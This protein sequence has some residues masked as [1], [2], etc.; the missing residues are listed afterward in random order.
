MADYGSRPP[1][2]QGRRPMQT[3]LPCSLRGP[4]SRQRAW[5]P[6]L[7]KSMDSHPLKR[8]DREEIPSMFDT[9]VR[10]ELVRR[11]RAEIAAGTYET[12]EKLDLALGRLLDQLD[13]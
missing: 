1:R 12:P 2:R 13:G 11:V 10:T 6:L 5:W 3:H 7:E 4:V 9:G 8:T